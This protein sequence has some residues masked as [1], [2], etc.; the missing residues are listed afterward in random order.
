M[1]ARATH[2]AGASLTPAYKTFPCRT[3]SSNARITSSTG[4]IWS[5]MCSQYKSM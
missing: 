1:F 3:R 5:Q 2:Q 4:V